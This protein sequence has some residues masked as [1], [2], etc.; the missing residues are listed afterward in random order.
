[1]PPDANLGAGLRVEGLQVENFLNHGQD[2]CTCDGNQNGCYQIGPPF[3]IASKIT[4]L[5]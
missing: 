2:H 4:D 3:T 5:S 1:M